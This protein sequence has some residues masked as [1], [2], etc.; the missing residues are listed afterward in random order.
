MIDM[1]DAARDELIE[2]Y[3]QFIVTKQKIKYKSEDIKTLKKS[4]IELLDVPKADQKNVM[5][6]INKL[7][8]VMTDISDGKDPV[9]HVKDVR[10]EFLD[11]EEEKIG[12]ILE[13]KRKIDEVK[14]RKE[15]FQEELD[16]L[17]LQLSVYMLEPINVAKTILN[18]LYKIG[19]GKDSIVES[20]AIGMKDFREAF[21]G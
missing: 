20:V 11:M 10:L 12:H 18:E 19:I 13:I 15:W 14:D 2:L 9:V 7:Y 21:K 16:T 17:I 3:K 4:L 8:S 6:Q 1:D 5:R